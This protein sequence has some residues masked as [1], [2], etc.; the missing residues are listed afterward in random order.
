MGES[1]GRVQSSNEIEFILV[2]D[3]SDVLLRTKIF[4]EK[5]VLNCTQE[6]WGLNYRTHSN[7]LPFRWPKDKVLAILVYSFERIHW[8]PC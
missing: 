4:S 8:Q 2:V 1:R 6:W 3:I 7:F 5:S